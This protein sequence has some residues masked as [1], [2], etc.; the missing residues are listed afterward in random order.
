MRMIPINTNKTLRTLF[1]TEYVLV[2]IVT[3]SI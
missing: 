1:G 2:I 3:V